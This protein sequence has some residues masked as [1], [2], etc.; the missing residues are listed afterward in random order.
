VLVAARVMEHDAARGL[1]R[2]EFAG[3]HLLM[4]LH[5]APPGT[6]LRLRLR[7]RDVAIALARPADISVQNILPAVISA[8]LPTTSPHEVFLHL[9]L[10]ETRLLA[11]VTRDA[12]ERL[13]LAPGLE[14]FALVK[15]VAFDHARPA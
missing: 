2:L 5:S 8:I 11:R 4:P 7:A 13:Q 12:A 15:S 3:G 14:V 10:G 9:A 6:T 1:T